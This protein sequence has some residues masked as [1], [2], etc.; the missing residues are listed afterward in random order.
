MVMVLLTVVRSVTVGLG[1]L[2]GGPCSAPTTPAV[3]G[4]LVLLPWG[5]CVG[6]EEE[7]EEKEGDGG[8]EG[9]GGGWRRRR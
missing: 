7:K 9:G 2:M 6:E 3:M 8:E 4:P 5:E 1:T